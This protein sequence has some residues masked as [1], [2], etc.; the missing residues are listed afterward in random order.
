M[1]TFSGLV[2]GILKIGRKSLY[3]FDKL[4]QTRHVNAPCVLDFYIHESRQRAGLGKTLYDHMLEY[5]NFAPEDLA[6][7][8]PSEKL[9]SFLKKH[10]ELT[11]KIPQM[12]NFVIY[13]G[14][15]ASHPSQKE[16][17]NSTQMHITAR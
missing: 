13:E 12:N 16:L 4:G 10:Y 15:F 3:I 5:E 7:D 8:R 14:F 1:N 2:V 9:M 17:N 11:Q 6:I